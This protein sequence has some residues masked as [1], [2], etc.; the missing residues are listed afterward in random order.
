MST[1]SHLLATSARVPAEER[2]ERRYPAPAGVKLSLQAPPDAPPEEADLVD[3]SLSGFGISTARHITT[4]SP[5]LLRLG[6][7]R[8]RSEERRVGKE[9]R[10]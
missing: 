4:G 3:I 9:C 5:V 1:T 8:I 2:S 7:Q 6:A 10:L